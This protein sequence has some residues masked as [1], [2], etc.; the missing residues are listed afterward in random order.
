[1]RPY[2][3]EDDEIRLI[4][5]LRKLPHCEKEAIYGMVHQLSEART[6]PSRRELVGNVV[7]IINRK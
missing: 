5:E 7:P 2:N 6:T 4:L 3:V 1:M